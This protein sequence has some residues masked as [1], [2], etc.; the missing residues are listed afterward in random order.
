[1]TVFNGNVLISQVVVPPA[2][3]EVTNV[4]PP[5]PLAMQQLFTNWGDYKKYLESFDGEYK[6]TPIADKMVRDSFY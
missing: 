4:P 5:A 3:D 6:S 1:M 2:V